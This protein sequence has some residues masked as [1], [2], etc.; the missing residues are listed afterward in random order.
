MVGVLP[1]TVQDLLNCAQE[2]NGE[3]IKVSVQGRYGFLKQNQTTMSLVGAPFLPI[4]NK[5]NFTNKVM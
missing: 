2:L 5:E 4:I 3:Q 1:R